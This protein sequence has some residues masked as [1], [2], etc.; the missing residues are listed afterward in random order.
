MAL[1]NASAFSNLAGVS[2]G[3]NQK[4]PGKFF[5]VFIT[6][7][8]RDGQQPG[9][10]QCMVGFGSSDYF[11]NNA[12]EVYF[13]PMYI[14]RY[15]TK[16]QKAQNQQGETYDRLVG[17]GWKDGDNKP[18]SSAK[19]EYIIA[20]YLWDSESKN[21]VKHKKDIPD[22]DIHEGD[23]VLI[24]FRCKG[25]KCSSAFEFLSRVNDKAKNLVPLSDDP[26][27]EQQVINPRRFLVK[28]GIT[29]RDTQYGPSD[30]FDF[31]PVTAMSDD[32]VKKIL[33]QS[34]KMIKDFDY[35]FD[36]TDS[37]QSGDISSSDMDNNDNQT[38]NETYTHITD[39]Q[40]TGYMDDTNVQ[41]SSPSN[42]DIVDNLQLDF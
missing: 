38:K 1:I 40:Y 32:M 33:E 23:S 27:F 24:Y 17:F 39:S 37:I 31:H 28:A 2:A 35:Q 7:K 13:I 3:V 36:K 12:T 19:Y 16:Y 41:N 11:V 9:T 20:G 14:K 42:D 4:K 25:I 15:W 30:S 6:G 18:D 29:S 10:Y 34:E 22:N 8:R 21:I 26:R 5:N